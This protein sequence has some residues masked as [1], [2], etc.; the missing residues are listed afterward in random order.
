MT[1]LLGHISRHMHVIHYLLIT[2]TFYHLAD[3]YIQSD[4]GS[5]QNQQMSNN[6]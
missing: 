6:M 3:A 2:F 1:K 4:N 5:N